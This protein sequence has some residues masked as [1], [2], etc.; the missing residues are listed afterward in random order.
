LIPLPHIFPWEIG[1]LY[2]FWICFSA[3]HCFLYIWWGRRIS[4]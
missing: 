4:L 2:R 1:S 3:H